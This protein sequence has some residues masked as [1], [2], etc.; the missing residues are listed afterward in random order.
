[1]PSHHRFL[2]TALP[3]LQ[4]YIYWCTDLMNA[5]LYSCRGEGKYVP[6]SQMGKRETFPGS[7]SRVLSLLRTE[8]GTRWRRFW[9]GSAQGPGTLWAAPPRTSLEGTFGKWVQFREDRL[10]SQLQIIAFSCS[11]ALCSNKDC[12]LHLWVLFYFQLLPFGRG[13]QERMF[14]LA[15]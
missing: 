12:N 13:R 2:P 10:R 9:A 3:R 14:W 5:C 1:M 8:Q 7:F 15:P 11:L 6:C 4:C